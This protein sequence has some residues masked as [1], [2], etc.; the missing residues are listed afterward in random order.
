MWMY[1]VPFYSRFSS[2]MCAVCV[3][4]LMHK[5]NRASQRICERVQYSHNVWETIYAKRTRIDRKCAHLLFHFYLSSCVS[6]FCCCCCLFL[7]FFFF[8]FCVE[9]NAHTMKMNNKLSHIHEASNNHSSNR[10]HSPFLFLLSVFLSFAAISWAFNV[11]AAIILVFACTNW[12]QKS[13][14]CV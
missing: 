10:Y 3:G 8:H 11:V 6:R 9:S 1:W 2:I 14:I 12:I 7:S 4:G 5:H 13:D